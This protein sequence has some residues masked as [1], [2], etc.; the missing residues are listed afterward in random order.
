MPPPPEGNANDQEYPPARFQGTGRS[1]ACESHRT[2]EAFY[3]NSVFEP[4]ALK[5][6][7]P[8]FDQHHTDRQRRQEPPA[9]GEEDR[10][11]HTNRTRLIPLAGA[12]QS[13]RQIG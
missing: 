10:S 7:Q 3:L 9:S 5:P 13:R 4:Q 1:T 8:C 12:F 6:L 11:C 2:L